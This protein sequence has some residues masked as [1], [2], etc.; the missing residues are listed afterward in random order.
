MRRSQGSW[1]GREWSLAELGLGRMGETD[2][3]RGVG[4]FDGRAAFGAEGRLVGWVWGR[5][6]RWG[7]GFVGGGPKVGLRASGQPWARGRNPFGIE[8][9]WGRARDGRDGRIARI[10][11]IGQIGQLGQLGQMG[12]RVRECGRRYRDWRGEGRVRRLAVTGWYGGVE[13]LSGDGP[14]SWLRE[15]GSGLPHSK[16]FG[17]RVRR[18]ASTEPRGPGLVRRGGELER[19]RASGLAPGRRQQASA[20]QGL[21]RAGSERGGG[22]LVGRGPNGRSA[23]WLEEA[24]LD[25]GWWGVN[26]VC[27]SLVAAAGSRDLGGISDRGG[28]S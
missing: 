9:E 23:G 12:V 13:S 19:G 18:G 10:G 5:N 3:R 2:L 28:S 25:E 7:W 17:G 21:R 16:A 15:S 4:V 6:P 8:G 11:Q 14:A 20:F 1:R 26:S 24:G 27:E 22:G